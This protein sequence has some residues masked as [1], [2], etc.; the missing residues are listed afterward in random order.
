MTDAM[1]QFMPTP[2]VSMRIGFLQQELNR[3][4]AGEEPRGSLSIEEIEARLQT[5]RAE[6]E[7]RQQ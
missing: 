1:L 7:R 5:L 2:E 3:R 6:L 4:A